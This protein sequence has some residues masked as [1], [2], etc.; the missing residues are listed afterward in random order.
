MKKNGPFQIKGTLKKYENPWLSVREDQVIRPDG[1]DGIYGVVTILPG[2]SVLPIDEEG[3][4]YLEELFEYAIEQTGIETVSGGIDKNETPL[5]AAKRELKEELGITAE[6]WMDLGLVNP[7][8]ST[9]NSPATLFVAKKLSFGTAALEGTEQFKV[10]KMP[11]SQALQMAVES[12]ITHGPSA[13]LIL[14]AAREMG[15]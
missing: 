13:V 2:I 12:K 14:K 1:K 9:V 15:F 8:T 5:E 4:V 7:F 11:F 6:E 10:L 3:N